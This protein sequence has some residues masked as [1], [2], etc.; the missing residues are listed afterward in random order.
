MSYVK[1]VAWSGPL[2]REAEFSDGGVVLHFD[3]TDGGLSVEGGM[4]LTGFTIADEDRNFVWANARIEGD[5]VVVNS[6]GISFPQ[7]VRYAWADNPM[8]I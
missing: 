7:A 4:Q 8:P 6:E 5:T 2:Y 1:E 3:H